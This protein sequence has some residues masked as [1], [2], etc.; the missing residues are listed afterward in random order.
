MA[1]SST[2]QGIIVYS[3]SDCTLVLVLQVIKSCMEED[4]AM[5]D[6]EPVTKARILKRQL[7]PPNVL[8]CSFVVS[9]SWKVCSGTRSEVVIATNLVVNWISAYNYPIISLVEDVCLQQLWVYR[10]S[11]I[12]Q[13][14]KVSSG[15][16]VNKNIFVKS[17]LKTLFVSAWKTSSRY[18]EEPM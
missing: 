13:H 1:R 11:E 2:M 8:M 17:Y 12:I 3:I 14:K 4:M 5:Q 15:P 9:Y 6:Y 7:Q 16:V 18:I 10:S